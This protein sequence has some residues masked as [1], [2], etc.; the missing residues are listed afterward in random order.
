MKKKLLALLMTVAM[1]MSLVACGGE[2]SSTTKDNA[3]VE[4]EQNDNAATDNAAA[5]EA[6]AL[7]E[8]FTLGFVGMDENEN[9][10]YFVCDEEIISA[11]LVILSADGTQN[12]MCIGDVVENSDGS[13]TLTD[14]EGAY[15]TTFTAAPMED[16]ILTVTFDEVLVVEMVPYEAEEVINM[17]FTIEAGSQNIDER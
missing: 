16:G 12:L 3:V 8:I 6:A 4:N 9:T 14:S 17:M 11:G 1:A 13:L 7:A 10:Y 5:D 2:D 15:Q